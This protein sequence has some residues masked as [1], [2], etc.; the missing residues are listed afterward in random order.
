MKEGKQPSRRWGCGFRL[1]VFCLVAAVSASGQEVRKTIS[2]PTP[3]Y[4]ELARQIHL[5]GKVKVQV[6][7]GTDGQI[8]HVEVLGGHPVLV[9][10]T[11][12]AL[13]RWKYAPSTSDTAV[14]LEFNFHP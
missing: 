8:K 12:E 10:A 11:L 3:V 4:P 13:K 1:I 14:T 9:D 7:V 6:I 2:Q 5:T